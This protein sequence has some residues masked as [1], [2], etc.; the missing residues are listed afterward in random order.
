ML[1][2]MLVAKTEQIYFYYKTC[3]LGCQ[4]ELLSKFN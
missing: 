3:H 4:L 2:K 1:L